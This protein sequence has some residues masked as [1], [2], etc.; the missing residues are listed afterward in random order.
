MRFITHALLAGITTLF[1][2]F[3][4]QAEPISPQDTYANV[5]ALTTVEGVVSQ[6]SRTDSGTTFI[7][8]GGRYPNH[9]FYGIIFRSDADQFT[10]THSLE[11]RTVLIHGTIDL[12]KGKPQI[13]LRDPDQIRV[14]E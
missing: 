10:G 8:F 7:N 13:V 6:V 9:V 2:T 3:S 1:L 12:Y 14:I 4:G 11:G 5:G